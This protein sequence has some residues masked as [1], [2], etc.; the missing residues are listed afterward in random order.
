MKSFDRLQREKLK[1][2]KKLRHQQS[3]DRRFIMDNLQD[4]E[5]DEIFDYDEEYF[6]ALSR[7]CREAQEADDFAFARQLQEQFDMSLS[8]E[9]RENN[10][11]YYM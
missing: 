7:A 9:P 10:F 3:N 6:D 5:E 11:L 1:H 2:Y 4:K 8:E